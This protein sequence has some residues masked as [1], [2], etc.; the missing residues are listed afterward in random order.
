MGRAAHR[1]AQLVSVMVSWLLVVAR[2]AARH[3]RRLRTCLCA[4]L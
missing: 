2:W 4:C 1:L 3:A